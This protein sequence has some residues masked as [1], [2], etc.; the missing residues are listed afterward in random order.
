[1]RSL[2]EHEVT[3]D[4]LEIILRLPEVQRMSG[5][6]KTAIYE[7]VKAKT[8]PQPVPLGQ[9]SVGWVASE[10]QSWIRKRIEERDQNES[11]TV[12]ERHS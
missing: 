12:D 4:T 7:A 6:K 3:D 5:L 1:M 2:A 8:F 11:A 9:R 10:V